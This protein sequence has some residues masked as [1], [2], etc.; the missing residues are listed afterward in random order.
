MWKR[1]AILS[2]IALFLIAA[3][4]LLYR[5]EKGHSSFEG[6]APSL[7]DDPAFVLNGRDYVLRSDVESILILGLD[8]FE[9]A[10][11]HTSYNNNSQADFLLLLVLDHSEQ[12]CRAI[13][14]NRDTMADIAV[15]GLGGKKVGTV[16]EQLALA[17]T[18]GSGAGDSCRNTASAVSGLLYGIPI[19]HYFSLT[20]DAVS[21]L[22]DMVGG[23]SLKLLEDLTSIDP[24]LEKDAV[25]NLKGQQA[26]YYVR[27][28][29]GVG[30]N[31]N[32]GRM[33]RQQQYLKA[34]YHQIIS[35]MEQDDTF[36]SDVVLELSEYMVSDCSVT[37]IDKLLGMMSSYSIGEFY[38]LEGTF[39]QSENHMEFELD[40]ESTKALIADLFYRLKTESDS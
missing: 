39:S 30:D 16:H 32:V 25:V 20:M 27:G 19:D 29:Y 3:L 8:T 40:K 24:E 28:R 36:S 22:N 5:W 2:V 13:H 17:H 31:S 38:S 1:I 23:V 6:E 4:C 11:D 37:E 10:V 18:Y 33:A 14:L 21:I 9:S 35:F 12:T 34:L 26:L 15:L 7:P